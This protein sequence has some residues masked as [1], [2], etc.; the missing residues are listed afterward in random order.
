MNGK[1]AA[2]LLSA[3]L[4]VGPAKATPP[5]HIIVIDRETLNQLGPLPWPRDRHAKLVNILCGAGARAVALSFHYRDPGPGGG[6]GELAGAMKKCGHV[7]LSTGILEGAQS[8]EADDTWLARMALNAEGQQPGS[9]IDAEH[10][11]L[12]IRKLADAIAGLGA[13]ELKLDK[14]RKLVSMPLMIRHGNWL[15]PSLGFRIF[16]DLNGM[17]ETPIAIKKGKQIIFEGKKI[18]V[19]RFGSC[20]VNMTSPGSAYPTHSFVAVLK[21]R[22]A[23]EKFKGAIVLVGVSGPRNEITTSTGPKNTLELVA[24]QISTLYGFLSDSGK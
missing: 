7:Y 21:G 19:D 24:D 11:Q 2:I 15:I 3:F 22:V 5:I 8:W 17:K 6:D 4:A 23:P 20:L 14:E 13:T 10:I 18:N 12:P 16:L 1:A 9:I